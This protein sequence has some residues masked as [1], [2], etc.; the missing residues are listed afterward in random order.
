VQRQTFTATPMWHSRPRLCRGFNRSSAPS[1][2]SNTAGG[3]PCHTSS[4]QNNATAAVQP[5]GGAKQCHRNSVMHRPRKKCHRGAACAPPRYRICE[6]NPPRQRAQ[7]QWPPRD[8]LEIGPR[9]VRRTKPPMRARLRGADRTRGAHRTRRT[10]GKSGSRLPVRPVIASGATRGTVPPT[11]LC[12]S[13]LLPDLRQD[14]PSHCCACGLCRHRPHP[15]KV[16]RGARRKDRAP[17]KHLIDTPV[18][19]NRRTRA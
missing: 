11:P 3:W 17:G 14:R 4:A 9:R 18:R 15:R 6:T 1:W 5:P 10:F 2:R 16:V 12:V 7:L 19:L 8:G 13:Q